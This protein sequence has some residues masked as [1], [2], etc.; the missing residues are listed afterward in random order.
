MDKWIF[1]TG[2]M[3]LRDQLLRMPIEQRFTYHP[4]DNF[5]FVDLEGHR[6]HNQ[7][8]IEEIRRIV[9]SKLAPLRRKVYAITTITLKSFPTSLMSTRRWCAIWS[10]ASTRASRVTRPAVSFA[11]S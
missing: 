6:V 10:I 3:G 7:E 5:F 4:G 1:S 11:Q 2:P 8:D 9:E